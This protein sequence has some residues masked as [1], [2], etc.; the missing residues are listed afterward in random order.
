M[1]PGAREEHVKRDRPKHDEKLSPEPKLPKVS[2]EQEVA[3]SHLVRSLQFDPTKIPGADELPDDSRQQLPEETQFP[4][5]QVDA[6][7][8]KGLVPAAKVDVQE[9]A[10]PQ[11]GLV[12]AAKVED[13]RLEEAMRMI[14]DL[15]KELDRE[16]AAREAMQL[17]MQSPRVPCA[18]PSSAASLLGTPQSSV[19]QSAE[20]AE[21]DAEDA[22]EVGD[23]KEVMTFPNGQAFISQDALRMRLRRLCE[24]KAKSQKCYVDGDTQEAYKRGGE[25][26]EW[27]EIA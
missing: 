12:P 1:E 24:T 4:E 7:L 19:Q 15:K 2:D 14:G 17:Q 11:K 10:T 27:L 6:T 25:S 22:E 23:T 21:E 3:K 18:T 9:V 13:G 5:T 20:D 26:R 16:R 8:Q